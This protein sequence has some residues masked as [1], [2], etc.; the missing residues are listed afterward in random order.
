MLDI[1][2]IKRNVST[3]PC[4]DGGANFKTHYLTKTSDG[5]SFKASIGT[6]L[7]SGIFV[8]V[9]LVF[10]FSGFYKLI[11]TNGTLKYLFNIIFGAIFSCAG[12]YFLLYYLKPRVFSKTT[13][14]FY[15][16]FRK[17]INRNTKNSIPLNRIVALQIIG[18][19]IED[20][21]GDYK[22]F[23]LNIVIDDATRLN[24]IDHGNLTKVIDDAKILSEFLDIPIWHAESNKT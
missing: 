6:I 10:F 17:N 21:D 18:E 4:F 20:D 19:T 7:F 3:K 1:N 24:V 16:G 5:Y 11:I 22:S 8:I 12:F 2:A 9:G 23:E 15:K 14:Y 13:N